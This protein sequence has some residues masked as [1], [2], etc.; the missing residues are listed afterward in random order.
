MASRL[1]FLGSVRAFKPTEPSAAWR[2]RANP[3]SRNCGAA[4][5][6]PKCTPMALRSLGSRD[7]GHPLA[8]RSATC[9]QNC[10]SCSASVPSREEA[11]DSLSE[12]ERKHS[13]LQPC[14][15]EASWRLMGGEIGFSSRTLAAS[16]PTGAAS[17]SGADIECRAGT[18][19]WEISHD[20]KS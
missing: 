9:R 4:S 10:D 17:L 11:A 7:I 3:R 6:K 19:C 8:L 1:H 16:D 13:D 2:R 14:D 5:A 20:T 18:D 15:T 12:A